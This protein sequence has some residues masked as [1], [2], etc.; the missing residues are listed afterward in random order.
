VT[1]EV[2][3]A[4]REFSLDQNYPNPFNPTTKIQFTVPA[5]RQATLKVYNTLGQEVADLFDGV[6]TAGEYH[7]VTFD[8]SKLATGVY[9]YRITAGSYSQTKKLALIK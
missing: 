8:A 3:L 2:G 5:D 6:A 1:V 4:P 7:Q 9:L